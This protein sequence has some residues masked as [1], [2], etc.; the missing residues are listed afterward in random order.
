ML[1]VSLFIEFLRTRPS[2]VVWAAALAQAVLWTLVPALFYAAPP[3]ELAE[4]LAIGHEFQLGSDLGPPL[5][6][7]L[8]EIAYR[9]LGLFGVYLLSQI[10]VV[11]VYWTVFTLGRAIVGV[12]H[13]AMAVLLMVGVA[14][15]TVPTP[16]FGP[17]ILAAA[18]W[19][20]ALLH[21]WR[22][23]G[24]GQRIY[25]FVLGVD[26]G[27]LL[28]TS[29]IGVVLLGLMVAFSLMTP[30]GRAQAMTIEP[31]IA[32]FIP[33]AIVF[34]HLI[35]L[36]QSGGVG[37]PAAATIGDNVRAWGRLI[38]VL[39]AGHAGL[40]V[41]VALGRGFTL[42]PSA[43]AVEI[44]RPPIASEA[45]AFV[46]FFAL[47]PALASGLLALFASR[48][49]IFV[50]APLAVLSGLAVIVA[51]P[52]RV[53]L[54]HQ[55]A[56]VYAWTALLILPPLLA[57]LAIPLAPWMLAVDLRV[58]KPAAEMG[59]FFADSF[60]RRFG[61]PLRIVAGDQKIA[62]LVVLT[63]PSRP[64]LYFQAAP[65]RTPWVTRGDVE[66]NGA[67][68]VWP[69]NDADAT[70]PA[71]IR[72][73]FPDL[74]PEVPRAFERRFQGRLPLLRIGWGV[75]RPREAAQSK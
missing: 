17:G 37:L 47:A 70:L 10:C 36:D 62:A 50:A 59:R 15:F 44:E 68:V 41:L 28:L 40:L 21:Y 31:W 67:I 43:P 16:D 38:G 72:E 52:D 18:L 74:V 6:F 63:A 48:P 14:A 32:A 75:I 24:Q 35:W 55:R 61:S 9:A 23:V 11:T 12:T 22:A 42:R 73:R 53:R 3:G 1:S 5:S 56:S 39:I 27:L 4:T 64:S 2:T 34:P 60:Q 29:T 33:I 58:E 13:A 57:A 7:W 25:W 66:R 54:V 51:A 65:E 69:S 71:A 46:L 20:L 45:R 8:A 19:A 26:I 30:R 49:E